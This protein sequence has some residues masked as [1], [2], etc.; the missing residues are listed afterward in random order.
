MLQERHRVLVVEDEA[1]IAMFIADVVSGLGMDVVGPAGTVDQAVSL[2]RTEQLDAALLDLNLGGAASL[3]VAEVLADLSVPFAFVTGYG[4]LP[5]EAK[6]YGVPEL[7]KPLD[8][9]LLDGLL[10]RLLS[11]DGR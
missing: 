8:P 9:A 1:L 3:P 2:A 7:H 11:R 10:K 5:D 4:T 6:E